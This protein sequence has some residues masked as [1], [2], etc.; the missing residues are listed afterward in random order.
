MQLVELVEDLRRSNAV[1]RAETEMLEGHISRLDPRDLIPQL[2]PESMKTNSQMDIEG[3]DRK[4]SP[5]MSSQRLSQSLTLEQKFDICVRELE[6]MKE[7]QKKLKKTSQK[8]LQNYKATIEERDIHLAEIKM[9]SYEFD[10]DIAKPL[11]EKKGV[12]VPPEKILRYREDR[13]KARKTQ[14]EK[15]HLKNMA[16]GVRMR[17]L[18][19]QL[20][21]EEIVEAPDEIEVELMKIQNRRHLEKIDKSKRDLLRLKR[22]AYST[23][24]ELNTN[25][26]KYQILCEES[27]MLCEDIAL[28]K[29]M[30]QKI[31]EET[32]Q[33]EEERAKAET[34]NRRL[35]AQLE[36]LGVPPV[37]EYVETKARH[38][39]LEQSVKA[40]RRKI[41]IA[42]MALKTHTQAWKQKLEGPVRPGQSILSKR[43]KETPRCLS[44]RPTC[45][46]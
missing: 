2:A 31:E 28:H 16:L 13:M 21:H 27:K 41:D 19:L 30:L 6:A 9:A 1:L 43:T 14:M 39:Q 5:R 26:K 29:D 20:Q 15:L 42:E 34:L 11:R 23:K 8:V 4:A 46:T 37:L 18:Q 32:Q 7:E 10:R 25:K 22:P 3:C 40:W 35:R 45:L 12:M 24:Q 17:N 38:A 33:V 44:Q 36:H